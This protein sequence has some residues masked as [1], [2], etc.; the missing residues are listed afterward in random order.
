MSNGTFVRSIEFFNTK[1]IIDFNLKK[2]LNNC[3]YMDF[4]REH[5][6]SLKQYIRYI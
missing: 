6:V 3:R 4:T 2:V 5:Y 1:S